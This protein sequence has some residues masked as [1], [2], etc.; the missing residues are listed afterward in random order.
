MRLTEE[1]KR[2]KLTKR[3]YKAI[4]TCY[5]NSPGACADKLGEYENIDTD[6]EHLNKINKAFGVLKSIFDLTS[7]P[8]LLK[9]LYDEHKITAENRLLLE[10]MLIRG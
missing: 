8:V 1:I 9:A 2:P 5:F 10:E 6:P 3:K 7:I 4:N